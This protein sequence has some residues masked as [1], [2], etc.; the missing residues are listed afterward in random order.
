MHQS[1]R[2]TIE[3]VDGRSAVCDTQ[4]GDLHYPD[5]ITDLK[6]LYGHAMQRGG[7]PAGQTLLARVA[8]GERPVSEMISQAS[9]L[10]PAIRGRLGR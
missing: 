2:F 9:E 3:E 10:H 6:V 7:E 5:C 1:R 8:A 4:T